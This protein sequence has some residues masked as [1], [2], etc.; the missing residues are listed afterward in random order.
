MPKFDSISEGVSAG[1][2]VGLF[3]L[4]G[5]LLLRESV[6]L[7]LFLA[8]LGTLSASW[9]AAG[10]KSTE[11]PSIPH[12]TTSEPNREGR[13]IQTKEDFKQRQKKQRHPHRSSWFFWKNPRKKL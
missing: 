9:I 5:F 8:M 10:W 2:W 7:S 12:E 11:L 1:L 13:L 3:F 4:V 6:A